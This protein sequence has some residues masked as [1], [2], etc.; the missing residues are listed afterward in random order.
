MRNALFLNIAKICKFSG[1]NAAIRP[2]YGGRGVI[3]MFHRLTDKPQDHI[4]MGGVVNI[5]YFEEL[6]AYIRSKN[7]EIIHLKDVPQYLGENDKEFV[8]ITFDDGYRDNLTLGLPVLKKYSA[9]ATIFV[10]SKVLDLTIDAWWLQIEYCI[11]KQILNVYSYA[12]MSGRIMRNPE[13]LDAMRSEY[14]ADQFEINKNHFMSPDEIKFMDSHDIIDI[15]GHT[16]SHPRLKDLKSDL[17]YCEIKDNKND[18]EDLLSR[19]IVTFAYPYGNVW[20][21]DERDFKLVEKAGYK[22]AVTTREGN[23]F[24]GHQDHLTALPR[25]AVR[26]YLEDHSVFDMQRAGS[27]RALKTR[28]GKP[29][30]TQ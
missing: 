1:F 22:V 5:Q 7:I 18:L 14:F 12:D 25:Y 29:F 19:D 28:F 4:N 17:A 13:I 6:I 8:V 3:L 10:P 26:G 11:Q 16:V 23:V 21:C 20:S 2:V 15:G 30:V 9:P 27:Y 24:S